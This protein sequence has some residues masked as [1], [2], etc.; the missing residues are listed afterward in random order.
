MSAA[1]KLRRPWKCPRNGC[2]ETIQLGG[3]GS[4]I[5]RHRRDSICEVGVACGH[6]GAANELLPD[7][8][9]ACYRC[10]GQHCGSAAPH[11]NRRRRRS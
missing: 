8:R 10:Y 3:K 1:E 4:H 11:G 6:H 2:G 5:E 7:G 9:M